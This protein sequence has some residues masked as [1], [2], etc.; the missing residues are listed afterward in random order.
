M[1]LTRAAEA[2]ASADAVLVGAGAG[3]SAAAG[4][5]YSGP[6]FEKAFADYIARYGF[7]DLYTSSFYE[8]PT[9]EQRWTRWARHI[10]FIRYSRPAMPLYEK[11]RD[12]VRGKNY[13]VITTNVDAQFRKAGFDRERM[14]EV[15]GDYGLMQ[16]AKGCHDTLYDNRAAVEAIN[17]HA[18]N[19]TV[20][21]EYVPRCPVCGGKMDVHVRINSNFVEDKDWHASAERYYDFVE[22]NRDRK[23]VMLE[24]GVGFNTPTIIRFPF[25]RLTYENPTAKLIRLNNMEPQCPAEIRSQSI[26]FTEDIAKDIN[27]LEIAICHR[28]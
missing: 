12:I 11:L 13:F 14:F 15:Q 16:C 4:L 10:D 20:A 26:I 27:N 21:S 6:E 18:A 5:R 8:F 24:I 19:I 7:S 1:R 2:I 23:I 25:E 28:S 9:E 22:R 3:L 17:R